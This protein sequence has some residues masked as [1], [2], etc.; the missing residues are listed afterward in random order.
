MFTMVL[1][2]PTLIVPIYSSTPGPLASL[3][4]TLLRLFSPGSSVMSTLPASIMSSQFT[5]ARLPWQHSPGS[6][7]HLGTL[8]TS[9]SIALFLPNLTTY[10]F[11]SAQSLTFSPFPTLNK[12]INSGLSIQTDHHTTFG[13]DQL[14]SVKYLSREV[15][16]APYHWLWWNHPWSMYL[17]M[18][19]LSGPVAETSILCFSHWTVQTREREWFPGLLVW[20]NPRVFHWESGV[21]SRAW[22]WR[23]ITQ[24]WRM[25]CKRKKRQRWMQLEP[26]RCM[27]RTKLCLKPALV[28]NF[29]FYKLIHSLLR[30]PW[31][32]QEAYEIILLHQWFWGRSLR[33]CFLPR[34]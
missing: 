12:W 34:S 27:P 29:L 20:T 14:L 11:S 26:N 16:K 2:I 22:T 28:W 5:P 33:K 8:F 15:P 24:K 10:E 31:Q 18:G 19:L 25:M 4:N 13:A 17:G 7:P 21:M 6:T 32:Q 9:H 30:F 23:T 3:P 1:H